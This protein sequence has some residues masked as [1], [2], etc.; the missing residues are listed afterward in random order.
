MYRCSLCLLLTALLPACNSFAPPSCMPPDKG[1]VVYVTGEGW[2]VQLGIPV[3][4]LDRNLAFYRKIFPHARV[5]TFGYG[6]KTFFIAPSDTISEYLVGPVPGPAA[7]QVVGL[8]VTPIKAYP[9]EE[10]ITLHLP[11]GGRRA[12]SEYIWKDLSKDQGGKPIVIGQSTDPIGLFYAAE[13]EYNLL[14]TCNTWAVDA[15]H[16]AG[17]PVSGDGV[18]FSGEAMDRVADA[19]ESQCGLR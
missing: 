6:K 18:V 1:D 4:E 14:H 11:P 17:L 12:L 9:P 5:I 3:R 15:L 13:S 19:A 8:K 10:T 7:I 2:H 16:A